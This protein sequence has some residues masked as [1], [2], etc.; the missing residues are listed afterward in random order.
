MGMDLDEESLDDSMEEEGERSL[1]DSESVAEDEEWLVNRLVDD[2]TN[3]DE[4]SLGD[5]QQDIA[6]SPDLSS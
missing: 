4:E 2:A 1:V 5:L 6:A 3:N